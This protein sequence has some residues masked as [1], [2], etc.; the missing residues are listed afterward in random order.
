TGST[1]QALVRTLWL[2]AVAA[3]LVPA[4]GGLVAGLAGRAS[5]APYAAAGA[6]AF[7]IPGSALAVGVT[8]GYGRLLAGSAVIILIAYLAKFWALGH[9]PIQAGP[10]PLPPG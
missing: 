7:A 1:G 3:V 10:H 5:R 6:V 2:A 4:L 9:R 8:I